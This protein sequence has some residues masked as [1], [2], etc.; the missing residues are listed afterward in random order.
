MVVQLWWHLSFT[1]QFYLLF[2]LFCFF[3][4]VLGVVHSWSFACSI[5]FSLL[6]S[7]VDTHCISL[8][9]IIA[10]IINP[11]KSSAN[12]LLDPIKVQQRLLIL[13]HN[14][15]FV[16][17]KSNRNRTLQSPW[18][19]VLYLNLLLSF[20]RITLQCRFMHIFVLYM[21]WFRYIS[22]ASCFDGNTQLK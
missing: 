10:Y 22:N 20:L 15:S 7:L 2:M 19:C 5:Y 13:N 12:K 18:A 21:Y 6:K 3:H 4:I 11:E 14:V 1:L 17:V 9:Y 16:F 8:P